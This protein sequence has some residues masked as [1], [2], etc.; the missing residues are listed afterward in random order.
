M[1]KRLM[2]FI[3]RKLDKS[4]DRLFCKKNL[5][6]FSV[7]LLCMYFAYGINSDDAMLSLKSKTITCSSPLEAARLSDGS[8][9]LNDTGMRILCITPDGKLKY[10]INAKENQQFTGMTVDKND[11]LYMYVSTSADKNLSV[12]NDRICMYNSDGEYEETVYTIDY[13]SEK[14]DREH[15]IRTS[16]LRVEDGK[17]FF[18]RYLTYDTQLYKT[19]LSTG[20]TQLEGTI[21][22][23]TPF[24]YTDVEEHDNGEYYYSKITGE[25]GSGRIGGTQNVIYSGSYNIA[26]NKGFRP[27]YVRYAGG[28]LYAYDYWE[29]KIYLIGN[30]TIS[31]PEWTGEVDFNSGAYELSTQ[32]GVLTGISDNKP[33]YVEN[34]VVRELPQ[35]AVVPFMMVL[36]ESAM[37][38]L[39]KISLPV[40]AVSGI[41]IVLCLIYLVV[42]K[43]RHIAWKLL[44]YGFFI[45]IGF[46]VLTFSIFTSEYNNYINRSTVYLEKEARLTAKLLNGTDVLALRNNTSLSS[47][48]YKTICNQLVESYSLY[49]SE[50]DTAALLLIPTSGN[51][52]YCIAASNRGYGDILGTSSIYNDL[53]ETAQNNNGSACK[54]MGDY[55]TACAEIKASDGKPAGYICLYATAQSVMA[56]FKGLWTPAI[57]IGYFALLWCFIIAAVFLLTRKL[58]RATYAIEQIGVGNFKMRIPRFSN[59]EIGTLIQCVNRLSANIENLIK[60]KSRLLAEVTK[61]QRD[62]VV[63]L[64]S[65]VEVKSG[66]TAAHVLRVSKC[67]NVLASKLGYSGKELEYITIASMLHDIGKL[68]VPAD[69]LEK[70]GK[71]T[72]EEFEIIKRHTCDGERLLHNAAGPVMQYA[73]IITLE[74]HEKWNGT[75]YMGLKGEQIHIEARI[76]AVADVF[77][78]LVSRRPYKEPFSFQKAYDIITGERGKHFD[79]QIVDVFVMCFDEL[80]DIIKSNPDTT[81]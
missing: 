72:S 13:K 3:L 63:S 51:D 9:V 31:E 59:D 36:K 79:P 30:G 18:V 2:T 50:S 4:Y 19:D 35:S 70:P 69:I 66:Q 6:I 40:M 54:K 48:A 39:N 68:F 1:L 25:V 47:L 80:C 38:G 42:V 5:I 46:V 32:N 56:Q 76:T 41:Y 8:T 67:V 77:D 11:N 14:S 65:I 7:L 73:R 75:G 44:L 60:E 55:I 81:N 12:E 53:L 34:N 43:G 58:K 27:F 23:D 21:S 28:K 15:T 10:R 26:D 37:Q 62:V 45:F 29:G 24:L 16:P 20:E 57:V 33:W 61:S 49:E 52:T 74:H 78:A 64:A 71:L 22:A 17:L